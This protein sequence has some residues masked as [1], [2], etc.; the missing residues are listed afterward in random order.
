MKNK[1]EIAE[2]YEIMSD[3]SKDILNKHFTKEEEET[4]INLFINGKTRKFIN[5]ILAK[6][7][8]DEELNEV[9]VY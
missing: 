5:I 1:I 8:T 7:L 6:N 4:I 3:E 9:L 2:V